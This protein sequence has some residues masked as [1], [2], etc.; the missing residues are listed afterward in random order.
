[1]SCCFFSNF[2]LLIIQNGNLQPKISFRSIWINNFNVKG[3]SGYNKVV[4]T[5]P[6]L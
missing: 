2:K 3:D 5:L 4:L 6:I 1:M